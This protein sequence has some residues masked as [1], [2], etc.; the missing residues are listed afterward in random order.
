MW[1]GKVRLGTGET[2]RAKGLQTVPAGTT[3]CVDLP[4]GGGFGDPKGRAAALIESD[5]KQGYVTNGT[6]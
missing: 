6:R 3:V 4:G 5:L 1:D 2:L